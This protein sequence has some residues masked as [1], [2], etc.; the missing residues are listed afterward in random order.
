MFRSTNEQLNVLLSVNAHKDASIQVRMVACRRVL[1]PSWELRHRRGVHGRCPGAVLV[2]GPSGSEQ[3]PDISRDACRRN[4]AIEFIAVPDT[5]L[6]PT[7]PSAGGFHTHACCTVFRCSCA[8]RPPPEPAATALDPQQQF[9][10]DP[11]FTVSM[12]Q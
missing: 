8:V 6:P 4:S 5:D 7:A 2:P 11:Q 10:P 12:L 9:K 3:I 1:A